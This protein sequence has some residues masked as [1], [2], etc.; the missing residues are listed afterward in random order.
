MR[1]IKSIGVC[2]LAIMIS[3][4]FSPLSSVWCAE[5]VSEPFNYSGY[6]SPEYDGFTSSEQY[7]TMSDGVKLAVTAYLPSDGPAQGPFP[8]ILIY[9]PY[10]R[11]YFDLAA[12]EKL[13]NY[14]RETMNFYTSYGY[15]IVFA[16]MRG[17]GASYGVQT[18]SSSLRISDGK[19]LVDWIA[20]QPWCDGNVGMFGVSYNAW[21]Q[22]ATAGEKPAALKCI[23]PESI[24]FDAYTAAG[25]YPGGIF[26]TSPFMNMVFTTLDLNMYAPDKGAFYPA[27][28]VIDEDGDG[29]LADEIPLDSDGSGSFMDDGYELPD[30]PPQYSD[31]NERQHIYYNATAQHLENILPSVWKQSVVYRDGI[32]PD[33]TFPQTNPGKAPAALAETGVAVYN[34]GGWFDAFAVG[35]AQWQATLQAINH[36]SKMIIGPNNHSDMGLSNLRP[37]GPYWEYF[38]ED[39]E[40]VIQGFRMERLR[41][42]DRYLKGIQNGIE[43]ELPIYI[44]VMNGD[45]W[46]FEKEWPLA[47]QEMTEFC[48]EEANSLSNIRQTQGADEYKADFTHDSTQAPTNA[49]RWN[50]GIQT[51]VDIRNEK[52]L[53]CLTYT[54]TDPLEQDTE[55]T[56][57]PIVHLWVS[58]TADYG[59]FFVYLED[60]DESGDAYFV[61]D[62]LHRAGF[63]T[64]MP[65]EDMLLTPDSGIDV[66][67]DLPWHGYDQ[68]DYTDGIFAGGNIAEVVFDLQPTSWVFKKGHRIRVSIACA[69]WPTFFLHP[70]LSPGNDP[71]DPDNIVPTITVYRDS[72]HRS[73]I[74]LPVIPSETVEK[75]SRPFKYSGYSS[76]EYSSF[77][78]SSE[79]VTMDD[80]TRLAVVK[81]LPDQGPSQG[82]FPT[83]FIYLPYH[84]ESINPETGDI[85]TNFAEE[86]ISFF[87]SHGYAMV[88]ADMRGSGA[89]F[90][91]TIVGSPRIFAD[92]KQLVDWIGTQSWCDGN[93]GMIGGSYH[94]WTQLVTAAQKP[95]ALKCIIPESISF[96]SYSN[97]VNYPGGVFNQAR[98]VLKANLRTSLN[99]NLYFS[100]GVWPATPVA[101]EDGDGELAD[102]IPL[103]LNGDGSFLD[104]YELPD[105]PPQYAD[106][107]ERQHIYYLATYEHLSNLDLMELPEDSPFRDTVGSTG[108]SFP[109][110]N[111]SNHPQGII[112]S[113]VAVFN[114]GGWF[115]AFS[116]G[117]TEWYA[118]LEK[119]NPSRMN[120]SPNIH[121]N[122]GLI[123]MKHGPYWEYFGLDT[124][125]INNGFNNE[126]LRFLDRYLKGIENG[127]DT[128][129]PIYIYVMNGE[130]WRFENEWPLARQEIHEYYFD[131]DDILSETREAEG[132][133]NYLID[134]THDTQE[135]SSKKNRYTLGS[136]DEVVTRNEQDMKCLVYTT[137]PLEN[138]TEVTGHPIVHLWV[139][140]TADNGDFFIYLEDVDENGDAYLVTEGILRAGFAELFPNEDMLNTPD[141]GIDVLPDIPWHGF[142][143]DHYA[144]D[145]FSGGNVVELVID[146]MPTSWVFKKGHSIRV[147]VACADWPTFVL[148]PELSP[149]NDPEDPNNI[150]PTVTVHRTGVYRSRIDLPVIP[151]RAYERGDADG[152]GEIEIY[153]ALIIAQYDVGLKTQDELPGFASADVDGNGKINIFDALRIAEF[154]VG[155][156]PEL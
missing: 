65:N 80:E 67:P 74:E 61:T 47:R 122:M 68:A 149:T 91:S 57:H 111:P 12:G 54:M 8:T 128:E 51:K 104:D 64:L 50:L 59:D 2:F 151:A 141:T 11:E 66:L 86:S 41:F 48:F 49:N 76:Q 154:V 73:R 142:D 79:Y 56:G 153:D 110:N 62:G 25:S 77:S 117:T 33:W 120:M 9:T 40:T 78:S 92:G 102:E 121:S 72:E 118:T 94:G 115:D 39:I 1:C 43:D 52:D 3:L 32:I 114:T 105:N 144:E 53:K 58:S 83:I 108:Y 90:G 127:V 101:D 146:L 116:R 27:T 60:V 88:F 19:G 135:A 31:G 6:T 103:D 17:T 15:A 136:T 82:P 134:Y 21:S 46:R 29:D 126:R 124:D 145:I 7:V 129:P 18:P 45:G 14:S 81:Y 125:E 131:E 96:D 71:E 155:V 123:Q 75:V 22:F 97:N 26:R 42:T 4:L 143:Q 23:I 130:G 119:T 5:K 152:N 34:I 70:K 132:F 156:I 63:A 30:N 10:H 138:N 148:N 95:D 133:D 16:D 150:I 44:Y 69:D 98:A 36:P 109:D 106:G 35:T 139:S 84:R 140:S 85:R 113:G 93:V 37:H 89:S 100:N 24:T 137:E 20:A 28:P 107:E 112:E 99:K 13:L 38:G 55:V 147:S 87:T